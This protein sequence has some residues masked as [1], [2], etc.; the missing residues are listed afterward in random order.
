M[1]KLYF[2]S[3]FDVAKKQ[4]NNYGA[5]DISLITD[6][7]L[8]IDPFLLFN[9]EKEEYQKL[10]N[11][12]IDYLKFIRDKSI[13]KPNVTDGELRAWFCFSEVRQNWLGYTVLGNSGRGLGMGFARTVHENLH[14][15]FTSLSDE[16]ITAGSHLERLC[17]V[18]DNVGKDSISDFT[19][20][21]IKEFLL[22]YTQKFAIENVDESKLRKFSVPRAYFSKSTK[23][24]EPKTY[25]LPA[26]GDEFVLL[27]PRD[28]LTKDEIWIN[29][30]D[31]I[32]HFDE[33]PN[34]IPNE[35]LRA[36]VNN[37]FS[38]KLP[39]PTKN[40]TSPTSGERKKAASATVSTFPELIDY[41]IKIKEHRGSEATAVSIEKVESIELKVEEAQNLANLLAESSEFTSQPA[42]SVDETI[43]RAN[44]LKECIELHEG[45]QI[46][47]NKLSKRP[48]NEKTVQLLFRL[49]WFGSP[50]DLNREVNNGRGPVDYT[51]SIGA[52][53]KS[54]IEFKLASNPKL[55]HGL[56]KQT[57][58]YMKAN[59]TDKKVIIIF[60]YTEQN[61]EKVRGVLTDLGLTNARNIV[62]IDAR[63]DNKPSA[64]KS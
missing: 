12:I 36:K 10:H 47:N 29:R 34:S 28:M 59:G 46:I 21:L 62:V 55:S 58:I 51:A 42:K 6:L 23:T 33:I 26:Y 57:E 9:S 38:S 3:Y 60:C 24:W 48:S 52:L 61:Q 2:S 30:S 53:D 44:Y 54:I 40:K 1:K 8:F 49:V 17:L 18:N 64:S 45:Y 50:V 16:S 27:S 25:T 19:A 5:V 56:E 35:E 20:N 22:E 39:A 37:Y 63:N 15:I 4:L 43:V 41:Y 11:N 13:S 14:T 7:P 31:L 32:E